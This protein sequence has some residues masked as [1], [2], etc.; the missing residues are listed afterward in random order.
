MPTF[1][2]LS[3]VPVFYAWTEQLHAD[4]TV[5][6]PAEQ[7]CILSRKRATVTYKAWT[8]QYRGVSY[9]DALLVEA[10]QNTVGVGATTF[11]YTCPTDLLTYTVRF[12]G[13]IQFR[14]DPQDNTLWQ[15]DFGIYGETEFEEG[16]AEYYS[17]LAVLIPQLGAG[18][19]EVARPMFACPN[20]GTMKTLGIVYHGAPA[21][22]DNA[23][24]AVVTVKNGA[25][26]VIASKTYNTATQPPTDG[27]DSLDGSLDEVFAAGEVWKADITQGATANLAELYFV[28]TFYVAS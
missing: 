5:V 9:A 22:I 27:Y 11:S 4:P 21:G 2:T 7:G 16:V 12:T 1:P 15:I 26:A 8:V 13:P 28:T 19:D 17:E 24:T 3:S 6:T 25:G 14:L 23:N 20:P 18:V 10:F